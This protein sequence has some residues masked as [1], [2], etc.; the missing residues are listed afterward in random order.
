M[1]DFWNQ[2]YAE[3]EWA[4]GKDPNE[5]LK[6]ELLKVNP[7]KILFPAEGEGR[8]AVFAAEN[9]WDVSAIDLSEA[10]RVKALS[11]AKEKR[12]TINYEVGDLNAISI[13]E[14]KYDAVALI[15]AHFPASF[16]TSI[17]QKIA[18][19]VKPGGLIILEGFSRDHLRFSETNPS[20]GG[21]RDPEMLFTTTEM[22][23]L[24][25]NFTPLVLEQ[26]ETKLSEGLYHVGLSSVVQ[27]VGK[28]NQALGQ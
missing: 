23:E 2:R 11:L 20:A 22:S 3:R 24:F 4:Y 21:P 18:R 10:G 12:V 17:H 27:Y 14:E 26:K 16:K 15:F 25:P 9:G 7:G 28:K 13:P 1:K 8:N 6:Q 19:A 5:F